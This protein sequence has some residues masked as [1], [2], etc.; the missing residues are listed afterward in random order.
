MAAKIFYFRS[1]KLAGLLTVLQCVSI[2]LDVLDPLEIIYSP[3]QKTNYGEEDLS[4]KVIWN[5]LRHT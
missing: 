4:G 5:I 1:S 2:C 3:I